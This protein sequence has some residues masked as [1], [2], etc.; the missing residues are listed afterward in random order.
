MGNGLSMLDLML[1]FVGAIYI[2]IAL[3]VA[4]QGNHRIESEDYFVVLYIEVEANPGKELGEALPVEHDGSS[5]VDYVKSGSRA[6]AILSTVVSLE[7]DRFARS[8]D[9]ERVFRIRFRDYF[10]PQL[11]RC[12]VTGAWV[13]GEKTVGAAAALDLSGV[14]DAD[15]LAARCHQEVTTKASSRIALSIVGQT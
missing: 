14:A 15:E 13:L 10:G 6:T 4:N 5:S 11:E 8:D 7:D 2:L 1:G 9:F 12:R 3:T